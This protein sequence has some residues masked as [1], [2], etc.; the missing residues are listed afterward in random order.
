MSLRMAYVTN[1]GDSR[2]PQFK[3]RTPTK[4]LPLVRSRFVAVE[5]PE[6][7]GSR[8]GVAAAAIGDTIE[9]SCAP[10]TRPSQKS[11]VPSFRQPSPRFSM[12]LRRDRARSRIATSRVFQARSIGL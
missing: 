7:R 11:A 10:K 1:R 8:G 4:M 3:I 2:V 6:T 5:F 9:L 12:R